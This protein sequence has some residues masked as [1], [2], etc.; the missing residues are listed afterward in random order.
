MIKY[1]QKLNIRNLRITKSNFLTGCYFFKLSCI[2]IPN[3]HTKPLWLVVE[4]QKLFLL[5]NVSFGLY[6]EV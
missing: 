2:N 6:L 1:Y 5:Y 3:S 4:G